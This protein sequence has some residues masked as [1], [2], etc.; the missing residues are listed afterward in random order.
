MLINNQILKLGV[1]IEQNFFK[2]RNAMTKKVFK[3]SQHHLTWEN[4][5]LNHSKICFSPKQND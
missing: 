3:N 5:D 1:R 2:Q 4:E